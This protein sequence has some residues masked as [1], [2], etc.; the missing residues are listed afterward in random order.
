MKLTIQSKGDFSK[1]NSWL[2]GVVN[3]APVK[4]L[5]VVASEGE[6]IL[7]RNTPK[8]TGETASGWTSEIV[9]T[10]K[11]SD[12]IWYNRAHPHASVNIARIID[13]GHG[14]GGGGY[15]PPRPYIVRSMDE[16]FNKTDN[17]MTKE[18]FD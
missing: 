8:A 13:S 6:R 7:S 11:S 4:A 5:Q 15:V 3:N 1:I 14:T 10:S 9:T 12:I 17:A 16:V 18:L 2:S